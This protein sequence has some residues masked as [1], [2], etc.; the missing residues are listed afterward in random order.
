ML[1]I[2]KT[3]ESIISE[4]KKKYETSAERVSLK[5]RHEKKEK[6]KIK[7]IINKKATVLP[8]IYI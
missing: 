6:R 8:T 2:D 1:Q 7:E 3:M 4:E 5:N